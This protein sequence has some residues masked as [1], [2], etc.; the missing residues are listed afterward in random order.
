MRPA[1]I[2]W[3]RSRGTNTSLATSVMLPVPR[4][5]ATSQSSTIS[6]SLIGTTHAIG[7]ISPAGLSASVENTFH[8]LCQAPLLNPHSPDTTT[9]SLVISPLPF[10]T[11]VPQIRTSGLSPKISS[12]TGSGKCAT[13]QHCAH[14][15]VAQKA[16]DPSARPSW[17]P[18]STTVCMSL[19]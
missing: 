10:G 17:M 13:A 9:P 7:S 8:W 1:L 11:R 16:G 3:K 4:R 15:A 18:T 5:P 19:S 14:Q 2:H 6:R 12:W